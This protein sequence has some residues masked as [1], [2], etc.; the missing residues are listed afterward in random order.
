MAQLKEHT[1]DARTS[2]V[3]KVIGRM[4]LKNPRMLLNGKQGLA[5]DLTKDGACVDDEGKSLY[6]QNV[7]DLVVN[8]FTEKA[9]LENESSEDM[10]RRMMRTQTHERLMFADGG[11]DLTRI[12]FGQLTLR[13]GWEVVAYGTIKLSK[14]GDE[15]SEREFHTLE[16]EYPLRPWY[17]RERTRHGP[18]SSMHPSRD[19]VKF[20]DAGNSFSYHSAED[21]GSHAG[22]HYSQHSYCSSNIF[23]TCNTQNSWHQ[24]RGRVSYNGSHYGTQAASAGQHHFVP[25]PPPANPGFVSCQGS[26]NTTHTGAALLYPTSSR[27]GATHAGH[28]GN[29]A[30]PPSPY[31][32]GLAPTRSKGD[33]NAN[34][35]FQHPG[36]HG[37]HEQQHYAHHL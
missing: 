8:E 23:Q 28:G 19:S 6:Y 14:D 11:E 13:R 35:A 25:P 18:G 9:D 37:Q 26:A 4:I 27:D 15:W 7:G 33:Y 3:E 29:G 32:T 5:H 24:S 12:G 20:Y 36:Y 1:E 31:A 16:F 30:S 2:E 22:G 21:R 10:D 17:V 34:A